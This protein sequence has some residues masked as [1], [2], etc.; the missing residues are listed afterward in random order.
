M[1]WKL[2]NGNDERIL[3][4]LEFICLKVKNFG[5]WRK[6]ILKLMNA[7]YTFVRFRPSITWFCKKEIGKEL[8]LSYICPEGYFFSK[9]FA[10]ENMLHNNS[11]YFTSS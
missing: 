11:F 7:V 6:L 10:P 3:E 1:H 9:A 2:I 8:I 5:L 4:N